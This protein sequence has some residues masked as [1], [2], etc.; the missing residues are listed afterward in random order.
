MEKQ[1]R[2]RRTFKADD[3]IGIIRKHLLKSKLVAPV[4]NIGFIQP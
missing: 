1:V 3:K 2:E 4:M